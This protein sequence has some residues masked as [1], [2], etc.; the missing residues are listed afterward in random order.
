LDCLVVNYLTTFILPE[1]DTVRAPF[2]EG[3]PVF[4][5]SNLLTQSHLQLVVRHD[6]V[7]QPGLRLLDA[8]DA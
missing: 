6:T 2:L 3:E 8:E 1:C 7:I 4:E 5:G